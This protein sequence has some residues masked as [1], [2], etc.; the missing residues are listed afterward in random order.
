LGLPRNHPTDVGYF[1]TLSGQEVARIPMPSEAEKMEKVRNA[2]PADQVVEPT[3][4]CN[5]YVERFLF[6][7]VRSTLE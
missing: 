6:E 7:R 4:R 3:L 5:Q 2:A 1:T